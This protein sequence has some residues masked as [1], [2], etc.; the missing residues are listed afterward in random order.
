MRTAE[1]WPWSTRVVEFRESPRGLL[2]PADLGPPVPGATRP[3]VVDGNAGRLVSAGYG[4]SVAGVSG[5]TEP[6][7]LAERARLV[8]AAT[9]FPGR[10]DDF[11]VALGQEPEMGSV[12]AIDRLRQINQHS[13]P[14]SATLHLSS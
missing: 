8:A 2:R 12:D 1:G 9:L 11:A 3:I 7:E 6:A 14:L 5:E 13:S 10:R 4:G